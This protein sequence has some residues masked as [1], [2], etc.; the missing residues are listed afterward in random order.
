MDVETISREDLLALFAGPDDGGKSAAMVEDALGRMGWSAKASF[1][2]ADLALVD[3]ALTQAARRGLVSV[4]RSV[5]N[6]AD[7]AH[8][9]AMLDALE[10]HALP[11]M[12]AR[13]GQ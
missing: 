3:Q 12:R 13:V 5:L 7:R 11:L 9:K 1:V 4:P 10:Q 8:A 6:D 2:P